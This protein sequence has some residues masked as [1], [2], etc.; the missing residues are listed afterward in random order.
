MTV[1]TII[2]CIFCYFFFMWL[3]RYVNVFLL[4]LLIGR[5]KRTAE[6]GLKEKLKEF[7]REGEQKN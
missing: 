6:E 1:W 4:M 7:E 2:L 3:F 5:I